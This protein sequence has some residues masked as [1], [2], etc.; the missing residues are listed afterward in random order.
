VLSKFKSHIGNHFSFL[1]NA[2]LLVACSGG[3]DS[4]VLS[5]LMHQLDYNIALRGEESDDDE[6]FVTA[7]ANDLDIDFYVKSFNTKTVAQTNSGSIQMIARD[8][9]YKWFKELLSIKK[10]DYVLTAHHADDCLETFLINLSRGTGIEGLTGIPEQNDKVIRPLLKFS[11]AD[12]L[13]YAKASKLTW[14]EDSSNSETKYLR[15][16]IRQELVSELKNLNSYFLN[17]FLNSQERL[18]ESSI[19]LKNTKIELQNRLFIYE[20]ESIK[21]SIEKLQKL[22]PIKSYLYLLFKEYGFTAWNDILNLLH[23]KSGKEVNSLTHRLVKDR[24]ELLLVAKLDTEKKRYFIAKNDNELRIP[25]K[26]KIEVV[27]TITDTHKNILYLNMEKL[28]FPLV[29]RK[30]NN[31]DY[32]YPLGM[33]GKKKLSKYFK[34]EKISIIAKEEQWLLVNNDKIAWVIGR[35]ADERYKVTPSTK[36]ILKITWDE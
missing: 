14:R 5:W 31:G 29:L 1:Q 15:N 4:I 34:D 36:K 13:E 35:R 24:E 12:I 25:L 16:K 8:L 6:L 9:R 27:S 10:Y 19:I 26:L 28:I 2:K 20:N 30:W 18:R 11:R 3:L 23:A 17:N 33:Q 32:F 7:F 22:A 21:I